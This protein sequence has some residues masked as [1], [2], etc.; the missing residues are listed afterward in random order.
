[1]PARTHPVARTACPSSSDR[2]TPSSQPRSPAPA[3]CSTLRVPFASALRRAVVEAA[4]AVA[5]ATSATR[6]TAAVRTAAEAAAGT[7][8][9]RARLVAGPRT[10][11]V[12]AARTTG[13]STAAAAP[14]TAPPAAAVVVGKAGET[15]PTARTLW[16]PV[17]AR[18]CCPRGRCCFRC[19]QS[20]VPSSRTRIIVAIVCTEPCQALRPSWNRPRP[21]NACASQR[22]LG[23]LAICL[24]SRPLMVC[25]CVCV[26][27]CV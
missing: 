7:R 13:P 4:A 12:A 1:M 23:S 27:V 26:C 10:A 22:R 19:A 17:R 25:V 11:A 14:P 20:S 18:A 24:A 3:A 21:Q 5:A 16:W 15:P 9:R 2:S 8:W 6:G